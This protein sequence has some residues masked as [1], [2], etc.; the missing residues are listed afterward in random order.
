MR[1]KEIT[2]T[3]ELNKTQ[4]TASHENKLALN[5]SD[6]LV[7]IVHYPKIELKRKTEKTSG[8][9]RKARHCNFTY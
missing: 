7:Y 6:I 1:A 5:Y 9:Y 4:S 8:W 2:N 3:K